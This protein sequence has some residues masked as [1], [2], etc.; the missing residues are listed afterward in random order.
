[1]TEPP[2]T[3]AESLQEWREAEQAAAVARR[4]K[5]AAEAASSAAALAAEAALA[6][7][8][9]AKAALEA[10]KRAEASAMKTAEAAKSVAL[11]AVY[12]LADANADSALAD[13]TELA[14]KEQ[15]RVSASDAA[16]R[17]REGKPPQL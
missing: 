17:Q 5:A 7:S 10:S 12:D 14:A 6:T 3:T 2:K 9:A 13:A 16:D 4:G 15:Y 11:Q 1:M 8:V